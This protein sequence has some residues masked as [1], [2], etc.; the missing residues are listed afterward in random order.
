LQALANDPDADSPTFSFGG[1]ASEIWE[2]DVSND[3]TNW[4]PVHTNTFATEGVYSMP[5]TNVAFPVFMR[6][7]KK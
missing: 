2:F 5:L 1:G 4:I 7:I 6:G 3:L